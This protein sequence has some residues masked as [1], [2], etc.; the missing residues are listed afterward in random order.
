MAGGLRVG[1]LLFP[2]QVHLT[3]SRVVVTAKRDGLE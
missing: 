3:G 1:G 2:L